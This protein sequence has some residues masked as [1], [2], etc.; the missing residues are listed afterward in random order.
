MY[1]PVSSTLR[2]EGTLNAPDVP[3]ASRPSAPLARS[4]DATSEVGTA[5]HRG[6]VQ[7]ASPAGSPVSSPEGKAGR[8]KDAVA[9]GDVIA[10]VW[11]TIESIAA[12]GC[13]IR[14]S[15]Y[16]AVNDSGCPNGSAPPTPGSSSGA[17]TPVLTKP[18]STSPSA[19]A[20]DAEWIGL[21]STSPGDTTPGP[22][23]SVAPA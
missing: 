15:R 23:A 2:S 10:Q 20:P 12:S 1:G 3:V 11:T 9:N 8:P 22:P 6:A 5:A 17:T 16:W 7:P 19:I 4:R 13:P 14:T 21:R 18:V